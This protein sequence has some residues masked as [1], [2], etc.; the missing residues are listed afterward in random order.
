MVEPFNLL[1][2]TLPQK[3]RTKEGIWTL[4]DCLDELKKQKTIEDFMCEKCS[5]AE[6]ASY[7]VKTSSVVKTAPDYLALQILRMAYEI[8]YDGNGK[9]KG[10]SSRKL[11]DTVQ[12]PETMDLAPWTADSTEQVYDLYSVIEHKGGG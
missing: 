3:A 6:S 7:T 4:K 2:L 1:G 12:Y 5:T 8:V 9:P 10:F 11:T